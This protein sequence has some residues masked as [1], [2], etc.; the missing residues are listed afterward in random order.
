M[1]VARKWH[2]S[3]SGGAVNLGGASGDL[4]QHRGSEWHFWE[5]LPKII[6]FI[7]LDYKGQEDMFQNT[8]DQEDMFQNT[9]GQKDMF[10][11]TK[12]QEGMFQ[13]TK[14]QEDMF[15]LLLQVLVLD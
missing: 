8:K 7:L 10:Q 13:N 11:N 14:G 6:I 1:G 4:S 15:Q 3:T 5:L 2:F 9:K 12:G